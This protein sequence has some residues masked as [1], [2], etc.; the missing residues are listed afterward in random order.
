MNKQ[1]Y[2]YSIIKRKFLYPNAGISVDSFRKLL[3]E[4]HTGWPYMMI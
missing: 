2:I 1:Y 3:R 4:H